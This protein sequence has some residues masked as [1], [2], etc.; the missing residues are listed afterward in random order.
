MGGG[1]IRQRRDMQA[2][3]GHVRA[4]RAVVIGNPIRAMSRRDVDLNDDEIERAKNKI[5]SGLVL[6]GEVPLGRMRSIGGPG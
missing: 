5:A 2:T 1:L 6:S 4:S 3:K